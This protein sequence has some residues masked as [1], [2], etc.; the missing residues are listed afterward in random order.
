M[1]IKLLLCFFAISGIA[2]AQWYNIRTFP[3]TVYSFITCGNNLY[4]GIGGGGV[5]TSQDKGATWLAVNNGIQFGGAYIFSLTSRNDSIYA[6]G[7]GEVCFTHNNGINWSSLNLNLSLNSDVYSIITKDK[8]LFAGIGHDNSNGVY[9]MPIN[10][11]GWTKVSNGLPTNVAVNA[12]AVNNNSLF[13]GT[14][15][16]VYISNN[17]GLNWTA[18]KNGIGEGLSV[19]SLHITNG[20][21]LAGTISGIF[22]S[23]DNGNTW[24]YTT[25]L[26]SNSIVN[27]FTSNKNNILAGTSNG[28]FLSSDNGLTWT[29]F[30][31]ESGNIVYFKSLTSLGNYFYGANGVNILTTNPGIVNSVSD[32]YTS[33]DDDWSVFPNPFS[34][35]TTLQTD[36]L[37]KDATLTVYNSYGLAVKQIKNISGKTILFSRDNLP[38]GVY[39]LHLTEEGKLIGTKK[40]IITD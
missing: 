31:N 3:N 8:F 28:A 11:S 22:V 18:S 4:A 34:S 16:G 39:F 15:L 27:C 2:N 13:A 5:Y 9:R 38:N 33:I 35:Q 23:S 14:E 1:K 32:N 17:N 24:N 21:L 25:G 7:F 30:S 29:N 12:F 36:N 26:P 37:F 19:K 20:N 40:I 6:G 10:G